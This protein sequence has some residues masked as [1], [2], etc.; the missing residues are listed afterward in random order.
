MDLIILRP[1]VFALFAL[2]DESSVKPA[3]VFLT[4]GSSANIFLSEKYEV[5]TIILSVLFVIL[6]DPSSVLIACQSPVTSCMTLLISALINF[7]D[8]V[9]DSHLFFANFTK[10]ITT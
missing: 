10:K 4:I 7:V 1:P 8:Y 9:I 6:V 2:T 5:I 3:A